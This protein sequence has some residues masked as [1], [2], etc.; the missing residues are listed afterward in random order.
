MDGRLV[1][2]S[3]RLPVVVQM[4][5]R[6]P[7]LQPSA[8][9][10]ATGLGSFHQDGKTVWV[11]WPGAVP[12]RHRARVKQQLE[13]TYNAY[14]VFMP[15]QLLERFYEGY[16]N[17]TLWPLFHSFPMYTHYAAQDWSAYQ[18]ANAL[19][20]QSVA[21]VAEP[22]DTI[23][24]H[25]Y[26]LMLLPQL[27]RQ[28]LPDVRIGFF[29]HI[30]FPPH[31]ILRLLP[32][33]RLI[34]ESLLAADLVGF[35]TYGYM[36]S[37][38]ASV[39][40]VL[41]YE[42]EL[43]SITLGRRAVQA[44]V[45]PM[46]ID[47]QKFAA[48]REEP[49]VQQELTNVRARLGDRKLVFSISRLDYTKGIPQHLDAIDCLLDAHPEWRECLVFLLCVVPSREKVDRYAHLKREI[50]ETVGRINS[51]HGTLNW[52]PIWYLYRSLTFPELIALYAAA[53]VALVTPL[54]D[55]M[56]LVAKEYLAVSQPGDGVLVLSETAGAAK[57][58]QQAVIVN[59]NS[60]EE[61]AEA[62]HRALTMPESER[63]SR[64]TLMRG[65]LASH[66]V[67]CW[68]ERFLRRLA[69]AADL[70][71][72]ISAR[73]LCGA[74][75]SR[76]L[77]D[78]QAGQRRL[79]L[80]DYD[81][82][83]APFADRPEQAAP[84][85]DLL[86]LLEELGRNRTNEVVVISGRDRDSLDAWLGHLPLRLVA[87]HGAWMKHKAAREWVATTDAE[88]HWKARFRPVLQDFVDRIP[89]SRIEGKSHSLAWHYRE[90]DIGVASLAAKDLIDGLTNLAINSDLGVLRG[91]RVVEIKSEGITKGGFY[92]QHLA[93]GG[94]DFVLAIGDDWTDE[95]LFQA[96]PATAYSVKIGFGSSAA[97]F[98]LPSVDDTRTLL[99]TLSAS[100]RG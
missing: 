61:V 30:P 39:Q 29:L 25:D 5:G 9:G 99:Q 34:L 3:N 32:Q 51:K 24:V 42:N 91:N 97:R 4:E 19:F 18:E 26:Q 81:G 67:V 15:A 44:D 38:L 57:E 87:E 12:E 33:H 6:E 88:T 94:W 22:G 48:A 53:D 13:A 60:R 36:N 58:L 47:F 1:L 59:P 93:D 74:E 43:G 63:R 95:T 16:S 55:G 52:T 14:P 96:L 45:F 73:D 7:N 41:G 40:R 54:R 50:D 70:A 27:L 85:E 2:V 46:G 68:A 75:L 17:R 92:R 23:W 37:F 90:A 86:E 8:G 64:N 76:L 56:N 31:D 100:S 82:T 66:D 69:D 10:L 11:G 65:W 21:Q 80:L 98:V 89:G 78:F 77:A 20:A 62:L 35:H 72:Q 49:E 84:T 71:A 83:L 28:R 79:L